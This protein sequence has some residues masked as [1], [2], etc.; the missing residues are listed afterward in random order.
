MCHHLPTVTT[1]IYLEVK[2]AYNLSSKLGRPSKKNTRCDEGWDHG[3]ARWP[4]TSSGKKKNDK[5]MLPLDTPEGFT[6]EQ[7]SL[8]NIHWLQRSH[9]L[10]GFG[11]ASSQDSLFLGRQCT[12]SS[13]DS[14]WFFVCFSAPRGYEGHADERKS[15][16]EMWRH[17]FVGQTG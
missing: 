2:Q 16:F 13:V 14:G 5:L 17:R 8:R 15:V 3:Q 11:A 6:I 7:N 10:L 12:S 9:P 1:Q 4:T